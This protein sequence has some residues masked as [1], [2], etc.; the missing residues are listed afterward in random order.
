M[1]KGE[2]LRDAGLPAWPRL[3]RDP[4]GVTVTG[5]HGTTVRYRIVR[6]VL[7]LALLTG[8]IVIAALGL[9]LIGGRSRPDFNAVQHYRLRADAFVKDDVLFRFGVFQ[10]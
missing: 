9:S 7:T 6:A 5:R 1:P 2:R 10:T 8:L 3:N 4:G